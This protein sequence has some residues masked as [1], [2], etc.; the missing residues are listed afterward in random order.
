MP[1]SWIARAIAVRVAAGSTT[2]STTPIWI[3]VSTPPAIR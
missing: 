1:A 2:S 3:A